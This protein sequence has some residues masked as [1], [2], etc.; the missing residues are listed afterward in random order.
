MPSLSNFNSA[1]LT[2]HSPS[3]H[4]M[5]YH[6]LSYQPCN[7]NAVMKSLTSLLHANGSG[8]DSATSTSN[9][10][11][12]ETNPQGSVSTLVQGLAS[13]WLEHDESIVGDG[14]GWYSRYSRY[15]RYS[16]LFHT[17][18]FAVTHFLQ[19]LLPAFKHWFYQNLNL[20]TPTSSSNAPIY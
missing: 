9:D 6:V 20:H 12:T 10:H 15:S 1:L 2:S 17:I 16:S 8:S 19:N 4:T 7:T 14:T 18:L 5:V 3:N 11:D 13:L